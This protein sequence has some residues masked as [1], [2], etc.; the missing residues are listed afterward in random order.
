MRSKESTDRE[1][2][3]SLICWRA[4]SMRE[5]LLRF[6]SA[7][8]AMNR[9][10]ENLSGATSTE[11]LALWSAVDPHLSA[12]LYAGDR[13][14][15]KPEIEAALSAGKIV[16]ADRYIGSN[17]AHQSARVPPEKREEFFAWLKQLEYGLYGLP[18]EDLVVYLRVPVAEAHRLVGLKSARAYTSLKRDIQ[19]ADIKHLEQTAIIYDRL[20]TEAN[21]A[22]IDCINTVSGALYSPEEIHRAVLQAVETRILSQASGR[23]EVPRRK[24]SLV[25]FSDFLGNPRVVTALRGMLASE[26]VPH[27]MLFSGPRGVGKFTLARM[28]AQAANCQRLPDDFCGECEPCRKIGL[29]ADLRPLDRAGARAARRTARRRD[30][31]ARAASARNASRRVGHR[32]RPGAAEGT[33][34]ASR[35]A[36]GATPRRATRR[37]FQAAGAPPRISDRR[38]GN[39][40]L[41][42]RQYFPEN[43][44]RTAGIGNLDFAGAQSFSTFANDPVALPAIFLYAARDGRSRRNSDARARK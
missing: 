38:R 14:E 27:A 39:D 1:S 20:A 12:L 29:L 15:A 36:R 44:G 18:V 41:G 25:S 7:F 40:A 30:R 31:R 43:S 21:W 16:L 10:L 17:M 11:N 28:F 35:A 9:S 22:R 37:L 2:A 24:G 42:P 6:A 26:R 5:G 13:L 32:S 33:C 3:R 23:G 34:R 4:N 8:R 19:E